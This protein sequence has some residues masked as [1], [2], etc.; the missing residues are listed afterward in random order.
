MQ[1][2][3]ILYNHDE[4]TLNNPVQ[5]PLQ[6][7]DCRQFEMDEALYYD[8]EELDFIDI[9]DHDSDDESDDES[10]ISSHSNYHNTD[11]AAISNYHIREQ[12]TLNKP[13][14]KAIV[15]TDDGYHPPDYNW[16]LE[17]KTI[18][19]NT[20]LEYLEFDEAGIEITSDAS[21]FP[22]EATEF[23]TG[24]ANNQSLKSLNFSGTSI[25]ESLFTILLP[26]FKRNKIESLIVEDNG[27]WNHRR[28]FPS[29]YRKDLFHGPMIQTLSQFNSLECLTLKC[30]GIHDDILTK[31]VPVLRRHQLKML[32]L[33]E[34]LLV[35]ESYKGLFLLAEWLKSPDCKLNTLDLDCTH[36]GDVQLAIL[37][38]GLKENSTVKYLS[39]DYSEND[40]DT[41]QG[42]REL[43]T[44]WENPNSTLENVSIDKEIKDDEVNDLV[45]A[46]VGKRKLKTLDLSS[47]CREITIKGWKALAMHLKS[48]DCV[49]STLK[50]SHANDDGAIVI[51]ESLTNNTTLKSLNLVLHSS[52]TTNGLDALTQ[53]L[54]NKSS[55]ADT[56]NSNHT[57]CDLDVTQLS[58]D[59]S[60]YLDLNKNNNRADAAR[61]KIMKTH[62]LC[63]K[64]VVKPFLGMH[65]KVLPHA[66]AWMGNGDILDAIDDGVQDG[67][68]LLY[69]ITRDMPQV[70]CFVGNS[71][72]TVSYAGA[73]KATPNHLSSFLGSPMKRR[74]MCLL[75]KS[76]PQKVD[77]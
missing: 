56:Y 32:S 37:A 55:I 17:G 30:C 20:H 63:G 23:L 52:I 77:N 6:T 29:I 51:A 47:S 72:N 49:L 10:T 53:A 42:V 21:F 70:F 14:F 19:Q 69:K 58:S 66:L 18:G 76:G 12:L 22:Q 9:Y 74:K 2:I 64:M 39:L 54:C 46:L 59:L 38:G 1:C 61:K 45:G 36:I 4:L 5:S 44:V 71:A 8:V 33:Q 28:N 41:T 50:V 62:F 68:H 11:S 34:C 35:E 3:H 48:P 67:I 16:K 60:L 40:N 26:L 43:W 25:I 24:V 27:N 15:Y 57:L 7:Q 73:S 65:S 75:H 13:A 31:L